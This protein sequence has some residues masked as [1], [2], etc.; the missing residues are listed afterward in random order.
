[1]RADFG[2]NAFNASRGVERSAGAFVSATAV[3]NLAAFAFLFVVVQKI[4]DFFAG[5][6]VEAGEDIPL[7]IIGVWV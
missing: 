1:M 7:H 5:F 4:A 6:F 3:A 2:R